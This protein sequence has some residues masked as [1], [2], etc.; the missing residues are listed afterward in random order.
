MPGMNEIVQH[1]AD[2]GDGDRETTLKAL[3]SIMRDDKPETPKKKVNGFIGYRSYYSA[4]FSKLQ[5]K[6]RSPF[7]TTL[8]QQDPFHNEW[9][10][11][12]GTYS[13]IR[14]LLAEEKVTLQIWISYA[15]QV[16]GIVARDRYMEAMGWT[17][18]EHEDGTYKL[19]RT[20]ATNVQHT[21][22]PMNGLNLFLQCLQDGLP[23][24]NPEPLM[25]LLSG[26]KGDV[27]CINTN[28]V[29]KRAKRSRTKV[30]SVAKTSQT[31]STTTA[32][33]NQ[34]LQMAKTNPSLA[35]SQL[36]QI[37]EMH[38]WLSNGV[39]VI[40]I[41]SAAA[42]EMAAHQI[43]QG[44]SGPMDTSTH[45]PEPP[46]GDDEFEAMFSGIIAEMSTGVRQ[47]EVQGTAAQFFNNMQMGLDTTA[48]LHGGLSIQEQQQ[49]QQQ[50]VQASYYQNQQF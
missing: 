31:A 6:Q 14:A 48:G 22:Q 34:L 45:T 32:A 4:L 26:A 27:M 11:M 18:L 12:C 30:S 17:L 1:F 13:T 39:Q 28:K 36:F 46:M 15:V 42:L 47:G 43:N 35:M 49:Q 3:S 24:A 10:F 33:D 20:A 38:P 40:A 50:C 5:Q 8:W 37:P 23:I 19:E 25:A 2:L 9:D 41:D 29:N 7:M 21:M 44:H 16:L